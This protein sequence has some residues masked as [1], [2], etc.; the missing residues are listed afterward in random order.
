MCDFQIVWFINVKLLKLSGGADPLTLW[1]LSG[2]VVWLVADGVPGVR[3]RRVDA[4]QGG[5]PW[6]V[7]CA[8]LNWR[9]PGLKLRGKARLANNPDGG[10]FQ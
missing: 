9:V 1:C 10:T 3:S 5:R 7:W 8:A 2:L 4:G 6:T